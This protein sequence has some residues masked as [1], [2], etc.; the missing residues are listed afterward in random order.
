MRL[1]SMFSVI[2]IALLLALPAGGQS[3]TILLNTLVADVP[4]GTRIMVE[5]RAKYAIIDP[6]GEGSKPNEPAEV[7]H[8]DSTTG[9]LKWEFT[10]GPSGTI[11]PAHAEFHFPKPLVSAPS[12]LL[13]VLEFPAKYSIVCPATGP[14]CVSRTREIAF[15][16]PVRR[17]VSRTFTACLQFRGGPHGIFVGIAPD[18][19]D[20]R[21]L[22]SVKATPSH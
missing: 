17:D 20:P 21:G 6:K 3:T 8:L 4:P 11:D 5:A 9:V 19:K 22:R 2:I 13:A 18:C 7:F 15:G 16:I 1:S 10:V 12:G 14:G